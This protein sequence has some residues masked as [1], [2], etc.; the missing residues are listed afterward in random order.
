MAITLD[1]F[2]QMSP[3]FITVFMIFTSLFNGDVKAYIWMA[4]SMVGIFALTYISQLFKNECTQAS[5][6]A[7]IAIFSKYPDLSVS[8]F[9]IIF[10][11]FYLLFP[12]NS[13]KDWNYYV[14]AVFIGMFA[15]DT[16]YKVKYMCTTWKGIFVGGCLG[17]FYGWGCYGLLHN[18][19]G[20]KFLYFNT[21]SSNNV[22]CSRP[23]KQQFKCNVYKGG[24]IISTI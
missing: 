6:E 1:D 14:L 7:A 20:D 5:K 2:M 21:I 3:I 13:N 4:W 18:F 22:Y 8:T 11:L 10:T 19:G 9:F 15:L 12:M 17:A 16:L 23:K 24:E